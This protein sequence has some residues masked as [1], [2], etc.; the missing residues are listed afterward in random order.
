MAGEK[1]HLRFLIGAGVVGTSEASFIE[2]GANIGAWGMQLGRVVAAQLAHP[3]VEILA[4][5]RPPLDLLRATY[6]GQ[7]AALEAALNLSVSNAV[8]RFRSAA[9]EPVVVLSAHDEPEIRLSLSSLFDEGAIAGFRWPLHPLDD[10]AA[11]VR[12][13]MTLLGDCRVDDV[14]LVAEV[15]PSR[16]QQGRVRFLRAQDA[17]AQ[18][19]GQQ[20]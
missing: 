8:R 4:M 16:D 20:H 13:M 9:G 14:R 10:I 1:V 11:I 3:G 2:T 18:P 6:A 17:D 15:L 5:P 12:V 19:I 7:T